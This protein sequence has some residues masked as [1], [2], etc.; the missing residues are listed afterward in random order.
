MP[1]HHVNLIDLDLA[2]KLHGRR[3]GYQTV[4]QLIRHGLHIGPAELQ[5]P[6]D[7]PVGEVQAHEVEGHRQVG[8][9]Q[10]WWEPSWSGKRAG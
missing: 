1:G 7:L 10:A 3:F 5:L 4:A 8:R 9:E 2:R 6:G